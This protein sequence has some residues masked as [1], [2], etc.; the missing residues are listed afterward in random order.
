MA[1][2]VAPT[3]VPSDTPPECPIEAVLLMQAML[4]G[5]TTRELNR[6]LARSASDPEVQQEYREHEQ[7]EPEE[8]KEGETPGR[9]IAYRRGEYKSKAMQLMTDAQ[10]NRV[11]DKFEFL[12]AEWEAA[13]RPG[14]N[15]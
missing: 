12:L 7:R 13:N 9:F 10:Y 4:E 5:L 6:L 11:Y 2:K 3:P 8:A 1:K 15:K 14:Q